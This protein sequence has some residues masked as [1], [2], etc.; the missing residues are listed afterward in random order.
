MKLIPFIIAFS[1]I[2]CSQQES[3]PSVSSIEAADI[4]AS[5]ASTKSSR[6]SL[7]ESCV[8]AA[9]N[10]QSLVALMKCEEINK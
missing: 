2:G 4:P 1:L 6:K 10:K 9:E 5:L 3:S 7:Y 8:S